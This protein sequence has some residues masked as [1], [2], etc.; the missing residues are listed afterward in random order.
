MKMQ[1]AAAVEGDQLVQD[2]RS[3]IRDELATYTIAK[4]REKS[5]R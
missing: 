5:E 3:A 1:L 4:K 2:M